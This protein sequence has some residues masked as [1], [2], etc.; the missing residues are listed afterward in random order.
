MSVKA[1][2]SEAGSD[3]DDDLLP[4]RRLVSQRNDLSRFDT[5]E[6]TW[7]FYDRCSNFDIYLVC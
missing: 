4:A 2:A 6:I 3:D 7:E 5:P 1:A